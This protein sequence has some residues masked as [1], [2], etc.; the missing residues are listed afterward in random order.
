MWAK[1]PFTFT[2]TSF[3]G[4][5][6]EVAFTDLARDTREALDESKAMITQQNWRAT[7]DTWT[8]IYILGDE[9]A[10]PSE[11]SHEF[12]TIHC[13][14]C[15]WPTPTPVLPVLIGG[16]VGGGVGKGASRGK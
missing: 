5:G 8:A 13:F 6:N 1:L 4:P 3:P 12:R 16:G 11:S 15:I 14:S 7:E 10:Y 2:A 9:A